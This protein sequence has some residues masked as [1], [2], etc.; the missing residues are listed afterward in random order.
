MELYQFLF[1]SKITSRELA[2]ILEVQPRI[3][4]RI[5]HKEGSPSLKHAI[6]IVELTDGKVSYQ[7]LLSMKDREILKN[8]G[9]KY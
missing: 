6:A 2:A 1:E 3:I 5:S 9:L 4:N 8:K 7:E